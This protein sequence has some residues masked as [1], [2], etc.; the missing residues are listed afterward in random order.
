MKQLLAAAS[1]LLALTVTPVGC[2]RPDARPPDAP[3]ESRELRPPPLPDLSRFAPAVRQQ[4]TEAYTSFRA[5]LQREGSSGTAAAE[6]YGEMGRLFHAYDLTEAAA[7]CY[8][9]ARALSPGDFRWPYYL[10]HAYTARGASDQAIASFE[11]A[12]KL[13]PN[14]LPAL[15]WLGELL[16]TSGRTEDARHRFDQALALDGA[17]APALVGLGRIALQDGDYRG[18][19]ARF[20]RALALV[21]WASSI[22]Y[23][24]GMAY[25]GLG[26]SARAERHIQQ[27]GEIAVVAPD[28]LMDQ[29]RA[30]ASAGKQAHRG[31]GMLAAETGHW[32]EAVQEFRAAVALEPQDPTSRVQLGLALWMSGDG[33]AAAEQYEEALRHDPDHATARYH[34]GVLSAQQADDA[35]AVEHLRAATR[36]DPR[37]KGAWLNLAAALQRTGRQGEAAAAYEQVLALDP[38]SAQARLGRG[39]AL[40]A[41]DRHREAARHLREDMKVHP[42]QPAFAHMLARL[43]AASPDP[44]VRDGGRAL[45]IAEDVSRR[46]RSTDVIETGAMALAELGRFEEAVLVQRKAMDLAAEAGRLSAA[47]RKRMAQPLAAYEQRKP[48]RRPWAE[49]DPAFRPPPI[50]VTFVGAPPAGG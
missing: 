20:E 35:G 50:P 21:P 15:V 13:Q 6:R 8:E 29:V 22:H 30:L 40:I 27:R 25:R 31:R 42:D 24:L 5:A 26:E 44:R 19:A 46:L 2:S 37:V 48:W 14:D 49:Q 17:S 47:E 36:A 9:N 38:A 16:L 33:T 18:A 7:V 11:E 43:L 4:I 23:M 12:V 41:L 39:F 45:A 32:A 3:A 1:C 10:G 28:P 34:R